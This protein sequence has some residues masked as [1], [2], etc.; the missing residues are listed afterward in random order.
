MK[1]KIRVAESA[2]NCFK[3]NTPMLRTARRKSSLVIVER[4]RAFFLLREGKILLEISRITFYETNRHPSLETIFF[5]LWKSRS[6]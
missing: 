2:E 5:R 6:C 1:G 4:S 3:R